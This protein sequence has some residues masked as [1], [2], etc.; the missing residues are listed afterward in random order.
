[1]VFFLPRIDT[2]VDIA[3]FLPDVQTELQRRFHETWTSSGKRKNCY[4]GMQSKPQNRLNKG[5]CI[6]FQFLETGRTGRRSDGY[7]VGGEAKKSA[8]DMCIEHRCL[9]L[10]MI[11]H[12]GVCALCIVPLPAGLRVG[13]MWNELGY[14]VISGEFVP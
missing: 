11:K 4:R 5:V 8:D 2:L 10:Y 1:M 12:N 7:Y 6:R 13:K 9:C 14:W 3:R